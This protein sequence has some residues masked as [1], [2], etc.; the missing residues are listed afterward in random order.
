MA[1]CKRQ[2]LFATEPPHVGEALC[3][4]ACRLFFDEADIWPQ[5]RS[6]YYLGTLP[7]LARLCRSHNVGVSE[8]VLLRVAQAWHT[9]SIRLTAY[10]WADPRTALLEAWYSMKDFSPQ[11]REQIPVGG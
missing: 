4:I 6:I 3:A 9:H 2:V 11:L 5:V 8:R 7:S 10:I 1:W